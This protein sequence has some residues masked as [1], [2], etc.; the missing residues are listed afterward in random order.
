MKR[1]SVRIG[2]CALALLLLLGAVM[3]AFPYVIEAAS[4]AS[5]TYAFSGND[6]AK[7]G[8]GEGTITVTPASGASASGY[9]LIYFADD[10]GLLGGYDELA[11]IP[12]TGGAV[13]YTVK[14][15]TLLPPSAT[16]IAVFESSSAF[17]DTPPSYST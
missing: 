4:S 6:A 9:Y 13:T 12:M 11:S 2:A 7:A 1:W 10:N 3:S 16:K 8:F 14:E 15:G 5:V 17:L